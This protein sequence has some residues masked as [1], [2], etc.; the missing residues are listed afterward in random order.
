LAPLRGLYDVSLLEKAGWYRP[1]G[2]T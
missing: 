1:W 2:D